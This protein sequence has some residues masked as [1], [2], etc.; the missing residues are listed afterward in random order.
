MPELHVNTDIVFLNKKI[1]N[2]IFLIL[3]LILILWSTATNKEIP[4]FIPPVHVFVRQMPPPS[5]YNREFRT[6]RLRMDISLLFSSSNDV[7]KTIEL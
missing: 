2:S 5:L 6:A 7:L 3:I 4:N 1:P